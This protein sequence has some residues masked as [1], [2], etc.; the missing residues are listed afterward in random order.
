M[1]YIQKRE[2]FVKE[3]TSI[4]LKHLKRFQ[5]FNVQNTDTTTQNPN[6]IIIEDVDWDGKKTGKKTIV[7]P[8]EPKQDKLKE[9]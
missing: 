3:N 7:I 8:P 5:K 6:E 1:I 2:T 4:N 9:S